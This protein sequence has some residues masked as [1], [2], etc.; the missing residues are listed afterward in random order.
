MASIEE[1][2]PTKDDSVKAIEASAPAINVE[3]LLS[4]IVHRLL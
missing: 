2:S 1:N 3:N 4:R